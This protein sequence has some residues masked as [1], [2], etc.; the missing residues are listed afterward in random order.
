[1][2]VTRPFLQK[3]MGGSPDYKQCR[4]AIPRIWAECLKSSGTPTR[5]GKNCFSEE[6]V[7]FMAYIR[8]LRKEYAELRK[9]P[10]PGVK[11][12]DSVLEN[13]ITE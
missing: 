3:R 6:L 13:N 8:I 12:D 1:M 2:H 11:L 10:P 5:L 9:N 4:L 7:A